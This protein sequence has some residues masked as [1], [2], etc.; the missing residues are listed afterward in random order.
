MFNK[1]YLE[2]HVPVLSLIASRLV[3][4]PEWALKLL[5]STTQKLLQSSMQQEHDALPTSG[6]YDPVRHCAF[7]VSEFNLL[8]VELGGGDTCMRGEFLRFEI[9]FSLARD[10]EEMEIEIHIFDGAG[11]LSFGTNTTLLGRP[12]H[13]MR[14]GA[15]RMCY[16]LLADLS[17][18]QYTVGFA[19]SE[20]REEGNHE[21]AWYD[22]LLSF[23]VSTPRLTQSVGY[24]SLPVM[25]DFRKIGDKVIRPVE[26]AS[27]TLVADAELGT[28]AVGEIFSLP[29]CMENTSTQSWVSTG[30]NPINLCYHW[31]DMVGNMVVFDGERTPLPSPVV[32]PGQVL[33]TQMRIVA[34]SVPGR[35]KLFLVPVQELWCWLDGRG[36]TPGILEIDVV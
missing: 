29:V 17:D 19:F 32:S 8:S 20:C 33:K 9:D 13:H 30:V 31:L 36:F 4:N 27:G 1:E 16:Y 22:N 14:L 7:S 10:I 11:H 35:Y 6:L 26:S 28:I 21:L 5:N 34:P 12:L 23:K 24:V 3:S 18:G 25:F 15:Y 2:E